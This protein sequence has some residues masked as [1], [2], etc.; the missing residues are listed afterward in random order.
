MGLLPASSPLAHQASIELQEL[1]KLLRTP[2][3]M[4]MNGEDNACTSNDGLRSPVGLDEMEQEL[5]LSGSKLNGMQGKL[6]MHV[7]P[8][9][10]GRETFTSHEAFF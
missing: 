2:V 5:D 3:G 6:M 1:G 10:S 8:P 7:A 9:K 4:G